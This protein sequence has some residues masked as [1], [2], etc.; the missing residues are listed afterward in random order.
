MHDVTELWSLTSTAQA[1]AT[2]SASPSKQFEELPPWVRREKERELQVSR[3]QPV[4]KSQGAA[5]ER[6]G[7]SRVPEHMLP[8]TCRCQEQ[9]STI[10]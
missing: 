2:P 1:P 3:P 7:S 8:W 9:R 6:E 10:G 4:V 5:E